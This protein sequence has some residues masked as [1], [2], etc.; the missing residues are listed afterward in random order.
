MSITRNGRSALTASL[1]IGLSLLVFGAANANNLGPSSEEELL[2]ASNGT[3]R[4]PAMS[5][6][7]SSA[8]AWSESSGDH[9][10]T[11][12]TTTS[13]NSTIC[14]VVEWKRENGGVKKW[15]YRCDTVQP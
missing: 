15:Q 7:Q 11:V 5:S 4:L 9:G 6:S 8:S 10:I 1:S 14:M 13:G 2:Q 3:P 12:T